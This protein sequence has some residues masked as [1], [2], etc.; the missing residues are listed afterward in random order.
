MVRLK[1]VVLKKANRC[2]GETMSRLNQEWKAIQKFVVASCL[3][4]GGFTT[5]EAV[6]LA[7]PQDDV[8][9]PTEWRE[10][11]KQQ[12]AGGDLLVLRDG[13][14]LTGRLE[15]VPALQ[16]S[17]GTLNFTPHDIASVAFGV[18]QGQPKLQVIT[19]QG[20]SF[21]AEMPQEPLVFQE[22]TAAHVGDRSIAGDFAN[23]HYVT[24]EV[25][26]ADINYFIH[27]DH[28]Y[29][30]GQD[31]SKFY[32]VTLQNGDQIAVMLEPE[33]IHLTDGWHDRTIRSDQIVELSFNGGLQGCVEGESC[34][35]DLGFAFVKDPTLGMRLFNHDQTVRIPW[36]H[37]SGLKVDLGDYAAD[38]QEMALA[39]LYQDESYGSESYSAEAFEDEPL[40]FD[41]I[42]PSNPQPTYASYSDEAYGA[43]SYAD[44][45]FVDTSYDEAPSF[46][47]Q[48]Y[49]PQTT[50]VVAYAE[51]QWD[52]DQSFHQRN[53]GFFN[54][55]NWDQKEP[56]LADAEPSDMVFVPGGTYLVAVAD[57]DASPK[58]NRGRLGEHSVSNMLPTLSG[59]SQYVEVSGFYVDK[60]EVTNAQYEAFVRA[61][62]YPA[63][64]HWV[65][66][67]VPHGLQNEPVVN[68]SFE[69][70]QAY[71]QWAGKRL[72]TELEWERASKEAS[73]VLEATVVAR[74]EAIQDQAFSILS[75]IANFEPVMADVDMPQVTFGRV[76]DEI[77]SSVAEWTASSAVA[78]PGSALGK[79]KNLYSRN[80][81]RYAG[82]N[83]VR[84]GFVAS[85]DEADVAARGHLSRGDANNE[86]GFRCVSNAH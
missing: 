22:R 61:T 12:V 19:Q 7:Y 5:A 73:N 29:R 58:A 70:A 51:P 18:I 39:D 65:R 67:R 55:D 30:P 84:R 34:D 40:V 63:P 32:H 83:V 35:E 54:N 1:H 16:Y 60:H 49:Q 79:V 85:A 68:V 24:R 45:A 10:M 26:P 47:R 81:A 37:I 21:I 53:D 56:A 14:K 69:D 15:R 80:A 8:F 77:S 43:D 75:L 82:H 3:F 20:E 17:F 25:N 52:E 28:A 72:P 2:K 46:E 13:R 4:V 62:R 9:G 50:S 44:D 38:G 71:A 78:D 23:S 42:Q 86:T 27:R 48:S 74:N 41:S 76:L 64:D 31:M 33:E 57:A 6:H 11:G 59:P 36:D 66:G